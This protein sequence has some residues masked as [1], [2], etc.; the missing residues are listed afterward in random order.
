MF[1]ELIIAFFFIFS[2]MA[3]AHDANGNPNW[4][5]YGDYKGADGV[6]CCGPRDCEEVDSRTIEHTPK[7]LILHSFKDELVP[8]NEATPSEDGKYWRCHGAI[9]RS[10]DGTESGGERRCFFAPVGTE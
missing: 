5:T 9:Y 6:H 4:I 8:W 10:I 1:K 3:H 2:G 7:G